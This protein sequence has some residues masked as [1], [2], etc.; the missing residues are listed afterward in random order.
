MSVPDAL[1]FPDAAH[2][3]TRVQ[4]LD[5]HG[6]PV[7]DVYFYLVK[8]GA[9]WKVSA[10]RS[11]ALTG[12]I[13]M[14]RDELERKPKLTSKERDELTNINL[15]L[16]LDSQ[17]R[18]HFSRHRAAFARLSQIKRRPLSKAEKDRLHQQLA[19]DPEPTE[20]NQRSE[21]IIGGTLDNTVGFGFSPLG[22]L[23][24]ID[25][26]ERIWVERLSANWYLFRTT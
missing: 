20:E 2:A 11:L 18:A 16:A 6:K 9:N 24:S 10:L 15:T 1:V 23:P 7:V 19:F 12:I 5:E 26:N 13:G 4:G 3:V 21:W 25:P 14:A 22:Q 8:S 17:L